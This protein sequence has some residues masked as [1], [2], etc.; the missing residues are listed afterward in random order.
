MAPVM[1]F[2][3]VNFISL[4]PYV[5]WRN[6]SD[7]VAF[8]LSYVILLSFALCWAKVTLQQ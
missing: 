6:E 5:M 2:K 3:S 1:Q 7:T 4:T 8:F